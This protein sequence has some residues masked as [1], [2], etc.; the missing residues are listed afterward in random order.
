MKFSKIPT[1]VSANIKRRSKA[2][3][4]N[5]LYLIAYTIPYTIIVQ[6]FNFLV[7]FNKNK[8]NTY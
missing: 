2:F 4:E 6:T 3:T 5:T 7:E 8:K 1:E